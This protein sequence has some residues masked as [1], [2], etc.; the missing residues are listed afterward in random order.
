MNDR[1]QSRSLA[2]FPG[3]VFY[4]NLDAIVRH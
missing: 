4:V 1:Y 3:A 2:P